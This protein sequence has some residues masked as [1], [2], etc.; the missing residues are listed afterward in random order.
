VSN[1]SKKCSKCGYNN[2]GGSFCVNCGARLNNSDN[3]QIVNHK[4]HNSHKLFFLIILII[5][6]I[7]IILAHVNI[8]NGNSMQPTMYNGDL[9]F[10]KGTNIFGIQEFNPE[11]DVKVG[12]VVVYDAAWYSEPVIGRVIMEENING[13]KYFELKGDHNNLADPYLVSPRQINAKVV[14]V[15]DNLLIIPLGSLY[16]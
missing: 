2:I 12:D 4:I 1:Q 13:S 14:A 6:F 9:V 11:T 15:G 7:F 8:I 16:F 3:I 5:L 10:I